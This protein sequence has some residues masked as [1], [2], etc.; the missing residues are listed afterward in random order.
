VARKI[1]K[2]R[3]RPLR[4]KQVLMRVTAAD[5]QLIERGARHDGE[6]VSTWLRGLALHRVGQLLSLTDR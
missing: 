4:T 6:S 1:T 3:K 2:S 5:K